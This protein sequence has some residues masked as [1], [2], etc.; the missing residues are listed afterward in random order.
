MMWLL[1]SVRFKCLSSSEGVEVL[2]RFDELIE[3]GEEG[4]GRLD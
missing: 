4:R 1:L 3:E 2:G